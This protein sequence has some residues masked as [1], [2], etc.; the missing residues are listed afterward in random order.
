MGKAETSCD[1]ERDSP[2][3]PELT[4][5]CPS[6]TGWC[7]EDA[8]FCLHCRA[9]ITSYAA[10]APFERIFAEAA[11]I[12]RAVNSPTK[13][14]VLIGAWLFFF[15]LILMG[16]GAIQFFVEAIRWR[17]RWIPPAEE[18]IYHT[19]LLC[20]GVFGVYGF[21]RSFL[22]YRKRKQDLTRTDAVSGDSE[23]ASVD[24]PR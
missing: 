4:L 16:V 1:V 21:C 13:P 12:G 22:A 19:G 5:V 10:T 3:E 8:H 6:C 23:N 11:L 18:F 15:P 20:V 17:E 2:G 7:E 14:I 24:P 9:P